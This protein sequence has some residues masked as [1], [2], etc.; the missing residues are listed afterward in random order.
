MYPKTKKNGVVKIKKKCPEC[1][2]KAVKLYQ[3]KS[4]NGRRTWIPIAWYC[5]KCGYTYNVVADT[6]MYKMG[7][8]PYNENFNKKCPKCNLGLVRLYRHINPKH[9]KQKWI[10]KGWYCT[11]CKYVWID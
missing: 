2:S 11:R 4:F 8:E 9:G 1:G 10:S 6:L 3:N 7:G 5:T